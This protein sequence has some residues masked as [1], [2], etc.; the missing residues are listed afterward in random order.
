MDM[1]T[2][3]AS[4]IIREAERSIERGRKMYRSYFVSTTIYQKWR[5][6]VDAILVQEGFEDV[7]II[8]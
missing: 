6:D 7:I 2:F 4:R 1:V 8:G 5:E 3:I